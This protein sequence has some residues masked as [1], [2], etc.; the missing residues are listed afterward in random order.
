MRTMNTCASA[1][2]DKNGGTYAVAR[3]LK[4]K[5]PSVANWKRRGIPVKRLI[6]MRE[7]GMLKGFDPSAVLAAASLAPLRKQREVERD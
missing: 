1:I 6:Q 3:K 2:I 4:C 7:R 5:P